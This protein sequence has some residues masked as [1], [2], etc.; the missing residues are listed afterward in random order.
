MERV[1][2]DEK[3]KE[4]EKRKLNQAIVIRHIWEINNVGHLWHTNIPFQ[5]VVILFA[6]YCRGVESWLSSYLPVAAVLL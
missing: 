3:V 5:Q 1:H 2:K 4:Q 6:G